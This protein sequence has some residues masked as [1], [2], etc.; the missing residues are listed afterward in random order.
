MPRRG[1]DDRYISARRDPYR[2][3]AMPAGPNGRGTEPAAFRRR[4]SV[5]ARPWR[6]LKT[7][8]PPRLDGKTI[9]LAPNSRMQKADEDPVPFSLM[10]EPD[11]GAADR[12]RDHTHHA[13]DACGSSRTISARSA[14]YSGNIKG[15]GPR[16]CPSIEDKIVKFGERDG[17][18]Y[19]WSRKGWMTTRSIRTGCRRRCR[20]D[21]QKEIAEDDPGVSRR[22][23]HPAAGLRDRVRS[24]RSAGAG[25]DAAVSRRARTL[26]GRPDQRHDRLRGSGRPG[27]G[28]RTERR[29]L[30]L[31]GDRRDGR[32]QPRR[33]AISA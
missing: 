16:Y 12:V 27:L 4:L 7:G 8:T 17:T 10:T 14:M 25:A 19:S 32:V 28:G 18:R 11:H 30:R 15:V 3:P 13:A 33:K 29:P 22:R 6:R 21:V 26:H 5:S 9:R 2:R 1:A 31:A 20:K 24:R 23:D